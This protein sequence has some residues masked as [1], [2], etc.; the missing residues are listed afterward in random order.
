MIS[1]MFFVV[2]SLML[3]S[4]P[5]LC[6]PLGEAKAAYDA[7]WDAAPL[8]VRR[9]EF[10]DEAAASY[11][12]PSVR[13]NNVFAQGEPLR[14][15]VEPVGY[16]YEEVKEGNRIGIN[17]GLRVLTQKGVAIIDV[18]DFVSVEI[19]TQGRPKEFYND[20]LINLSGLRPAEYTLE[21]TLNDMASEER[22]TLSMPFSVEK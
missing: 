15:Y 5:G 21:L 17:Y 19:M 7:A 20:L 9:A 18:E 3:F 6:D 12:N 14:L 8:A 13:S 22:T 1:R 2:T 4:S 10:V 11:D 16:G